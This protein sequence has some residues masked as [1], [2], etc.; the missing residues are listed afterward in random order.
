MENKERRDN[1][2]T[3]FERLS[4]Y[5]KLNILIAKIPEIRYD[6][7]KELKALISKG[8]YNVMPHQ[9]VDKIIHE[10]IYVLKMYKN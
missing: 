2:I 7:V 1:K 9:V 8:N 5:E 6:R 4:E 10:G 3:L